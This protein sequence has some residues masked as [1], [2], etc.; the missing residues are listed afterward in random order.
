VQ[1]EHFSGGAYP[2]GI[3]SFAPTATVVP[4]TI[5]LAMGAPPPTALTGR[6]ILFNPDKSRIAEGHAELLFSVA[7]GVITI[8]AVVTL[9]V[10]FDVLDPEQ[11]GP[12]KPIPTATWENPGGTDWTDAGGTAWSS[13]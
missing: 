5:S 8:D 12:V 3:A 2:E 10:P 1:P 7:A 11:E 6:V 9:V 4:G 13:P